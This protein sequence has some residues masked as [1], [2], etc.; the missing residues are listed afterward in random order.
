MVTPFRMSASMPTNTSSPIRMGAAAPALI[1][2]ADEQEHVSVPRA[3]PPCD[4][5]NRI[6]PGRRPPSA[7]RTFRNHSYFS[8]SKALRARNASG[9]RVSQAAAMSASATCKP[10]DYFHSSRWEQVIP[11]AFPS[12]SSLFYCHSFNGSTQINRVSYVLHLL[13]AC[14]GSGERRSPHARQVRAPVRGDAARQEG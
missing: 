7:P 10:G 1:S 9:P 13:S 3:P 12:G 8:K 5:R 6:S 2:S 14:S 4:V 11:T